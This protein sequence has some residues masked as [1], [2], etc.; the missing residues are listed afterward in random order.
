MHKL[1]IIDDDHCKE[2][3]EKFLSQH[4]ENILLL[5]EE[6]EF[7]KRIDQILKDLN[8]LY[9]MQH[10]AIL[11]TPSGI[12]KVIVSETMYIKQHT[13]A[14]QI[15]FVLKEG[16]ELAVNAEMDDI[17]KDLMSFSFIRVNDDYLVNV[18]Y[19]AEYCVE[20]DREIKMENGET[21]HVDSERAPALLDVLNNWK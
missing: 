3:L 10:K 1:L 15:L 12:Q 7:S 19:M 9:K 18:D 4:Q 2:E 16:E 17:E 8:H 5:L 14:N 21:I 20:N 6:E 11:K 13:E